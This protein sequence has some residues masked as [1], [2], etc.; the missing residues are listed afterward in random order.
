MRLIKNTSLQG[1][2][3][4]FETPKGLYEVYLR[5]KESL[6]VPDSYKSKILDNYLRKRMIKVVPQAVEIPVDQTKTF[7]RKK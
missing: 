2:N 7:K 4:S 5:P 3:L 6:M 1:L